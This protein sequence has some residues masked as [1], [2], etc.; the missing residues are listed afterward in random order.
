MIH[1]IDDL[2]ITRAIGQDGLISAYRNVRQGLGAKSVT[3]D[4]I[5]DFLQL[6]PSLCFALE[7]LFA[8]HLEPPQDALDAISWFDLCYGLFLPLSGIQP[9]KAK[10]LFGVTQFACTLTHR[11]LAEKFLA[12]NL[13]L[14]LSDKIAYLMGDPFAGGNS[15]LG[16]DTLLNA[17]ATTRLDSP[18]Q[19]R[20]KLSRVGDIG[21][22]FIEEW[23]QLKSSPPISAREL[24]FILKL[25]P[26]VGSNRKKEVLQD[27][28][29][30][31]GRLERY[32]LVR[33]MLRR[34][35]FGYEYRQSLIA[36][37]LAAHYHAPEQLV[38][39][40]IALADIFKVASILEQEGATALR[41]L[42]LKPMNP[43][44]PALAGVAD[45][46]HKQ[47]FPVWVE[48]KYD[49]IRLM[50]HKDTSAGGRV[51]YAAFTR[52]KYDWLDM[53]AGL[54]ASAA[55]LPAQ[56]LI[57]D[58]ELHGKVANWDGKVMS[59]A[60]V[61]QIYRQLQGAAEEPVRLEYI[62]FDVLYLNGQDLTAL[63]FLQ[64]RKIVESL[65]AGVPRTNLPIPLLISEGWEANSL[66]DFN[67]WYQY[68]LQQGHEGVIAK[69]LNAAYALG[70]RTSDWLKKKA[71]IHIDL[72][73]TGALW[74]LS[75]GGPQTF[76]AY[77]IACRD[78]QTWRQIGSVAGL[79]QEQN[80]QIVQRILTEGLLTGRNWQERAASGIHPAL[81]ITPAIVV[82]VK[83]EDIVRS[84]EG[85]YSLRDPK[86]VHLRPAGDISPAEVDTYQTIRELYLKRSL[87]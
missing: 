13:G 47:Q 43:V 10:S 28:L 84:R 59:P 83:F 17:L 31:T 50:L 18:D 38:E 61:Y 70:K 15:Y 78:G 76:S 64:R 86:I 71:E 69:T 56:S 48:C 62:V 77:F 22:L 36:K 21:M 9:D 66:A 74:A 57:L 1:V 82:T 19:L 25:L 16:Q 53:V 42:V 33:L 52:R 68:F 39:N 40:G 45:V 8:E 54:P 12:K 35:S 63:P 51:K 55:W 58:G 14:T 44:S 6:P 26:C 23:P 85:D 79:A 46:D 81:E 3:S 30:R 41:K 4:Y 67:K 37:A 34:L 49:G 73:I 32:F 20:E 65:L 5:A 27:L 80:F 75:Q 24:L 11:E 87:H 72:V 2:T 60:S 29:L 7:S